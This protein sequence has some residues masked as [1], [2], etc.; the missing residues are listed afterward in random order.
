MPIGPQAVHR[1]HRVV[2]THFFAPGKKVIYGS[3]WPLSSCNVVSF[4]LVDL[5]SIAK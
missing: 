5:R 3:R 2:Q 4:E 1:P